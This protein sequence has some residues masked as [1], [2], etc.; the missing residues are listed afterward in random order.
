MDELSP[1]ICSTTLTLKNTRD[2]SSE[3]GNP[4]RVMNGFLN[5]NPGKSSQKPANSTGPV[6]GIRGNTAVA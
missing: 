2:P 5:V 4:A 1:L 6:R 3:I